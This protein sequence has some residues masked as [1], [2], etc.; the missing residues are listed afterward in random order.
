MAQYMAAKELH[1]D[2]LVFFRMGDFY[3]LFFDDAKKASTSWISV[4][5][6]IGEG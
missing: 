4:G 1:P 5:F 2:A 3:E 6:F